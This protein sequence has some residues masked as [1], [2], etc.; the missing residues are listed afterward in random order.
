M[1][2][3]LVET[4][5]DSLSQEIDFTLDERVEIA[6]FIPYIYFH[7]VTGAVFTFELKRDSDVIFEQ[8]FTSEQVKEASGDYAHVFYPIIPINPVQLENGSYTFTIKRKSGYLAGASFI[9]WIK[10]YVDVQNEMSYTPESSASNTFA[11]RFKK[12]REGI[13]I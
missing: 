7:N 5:Q 3:L 11:I 8:D 10:Q 13:K 2:I 1:S 9:G 12:F 4:L 6:A